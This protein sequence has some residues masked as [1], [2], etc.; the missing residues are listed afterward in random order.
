MGVQVHLEHDELNFMEEGTQKIILS[1]L[2][3]LV[4]L[5][6]GAIYSK[7]VR[8]NKRTNQENI[9]ITGDQNKVVGGDDR[10]R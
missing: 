6:G 1:V 5:V 9:T 4:A 3:I 2:G 10:S 8:K 7:K